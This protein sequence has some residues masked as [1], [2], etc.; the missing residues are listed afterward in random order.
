MAVG[1]GL[2]FSMVVDSHL[3]YAM[4]LQDEDDE[5]HDEVIYSCG[6]LSPIVR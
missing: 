3:T 4:I 6:N 5:A 2:K 1:R